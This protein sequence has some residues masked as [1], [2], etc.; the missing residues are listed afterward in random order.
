MLAVLDA[1]GEL[2]ACS[3][4]ARSYIEVIRVSKGFEALWQQ[5][6]GSNLPQEGRIG[7]ADARSFWLALVPLQRGSNSEMLL[8]ARDVTMADQVTNALISSRTLLRDLLELSSDLAFEVD[9]AGRFS[10][11]GNKL[12]DGQPTSNWVGRP[13]AQ[14]LWPDGAVPSRNPLRAK[15]ARYYRSVSVTL[16][17]QK[18][19][20]DFKVEPSIDAQGVQTGL[21]VSCRDVSEHVDRERRARL[22]NIRLSLQSDM[23]AVMSRAERPDSLLNE[24]AAAIMHAVRAEAVWILG[25][26]DRDISPL[27]VQGSGI[28]RDIDLNRCWQL[29]E[30]KTDHESTSPDPADNV[31]DFPDGDQLRLV[32]RLARRRGSGD[33]TVPLLNAIV[34]AARDTHISPWSDEERLMLGAAADILNEALAKAEL[35]ERL[36]LLST[37]DELTGVQNRRAITDAVNTRLGY[38]KTLG[39]SGCLMFIDLD[40]FKEINDTLGHH[41]GD[42]A[43]KL[44]SAKLRALTREGDRVGRYGG[45]EFVVWFDSLSADVAIDRGRDLIAHMPEVRA[46]LG[47][48]HLGLSASIGVAVSDPEKQE[49]FDLLADKADAALYKVKK[50][51]KGDVVLAQSSV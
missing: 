45:D 19:F 5:A 1:A 22:A 8:I 7:H 51:G 28:S 47:A 16:S 43:L 20:W 6:T 32:M 24:A 21:A 25:Q 46:Q 27:A 44:V 10:F 39:R 3:D 34:I 42:E 31:F 30:D 40:N 2:L 41:A 50:A 29:A 35:I 15:T 4:A 17:D 36:Q 9:M 11:V 49:T 38:L 23:M 14:I 37:M 18:R 13:A 12:I 48:S 26:R 33:A